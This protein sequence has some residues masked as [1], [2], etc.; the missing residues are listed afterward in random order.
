MNPN[1]CIFVFQGL[2]KLSIHGNSPRV[3]TAILH[4]VETKKKLD[5]VFKSVAN[6]G[7]ASQASRL[8]IEKHIAEVKESVD[9]NGEPFVAYHE[10]D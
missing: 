1:C 8:I 6:N 5:D 7:N 2:P 10:T 3:R 9:E 4:E